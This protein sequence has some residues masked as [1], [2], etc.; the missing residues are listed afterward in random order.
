MEAI[1]HAIESIGQAGFMI[2]TAFVVLV[3]MGVGFAV[4]LNTANGMDVFKKH[5]PGILVGSLL[6]FSAVM[7]GAWIVTMF[8]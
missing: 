1:I 5:L 3:L 2:G 4:F 6:I 7:L 8:A